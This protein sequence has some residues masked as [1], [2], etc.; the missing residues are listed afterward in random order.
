MFM[1]AGAKLPADTSRIRPQARSLLLLRE[2]LL[3][4]KA[5]LS[6]HR[7]VKPFGFHFTGETQL[8]GASSFKS[9]NV[10]PNE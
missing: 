1:R 6:K 4:P 5:F 7:K 2:N 9:M 8:Q 3:Q 10:T